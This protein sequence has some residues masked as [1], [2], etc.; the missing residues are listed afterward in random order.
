MKE[1][2]CAVIRDLLPLYEDNAVS[3]E[4][5]ELVREH[6]ANCPDCR[7]ELR[8]MR[9][10]ISLP[11]DG[12]EEAVRRFL[13]RR[14][15]IR[16]KQNVKIACVASVLAVILVFCLCYTLIPRSWDSVSHGVEPDRIMGDYSLFVFRNDSPSIEVW[17]TDEEYQY[18]AAVVNQVMDALRSCSYRADL[19]NVL[20]N[21]PIAPFFQDTG[22]EG[23]NGT[24]FLSLVKDNQVAAR[25]GLYSTRRGQI[26]CVSFP[27]NP[28]DFYYRTDSSLFDELTT[29]IQ[30]YGTQQ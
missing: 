10:P 17:L 2:N 22:T 23:L 13:E 1:I 16:K 3:E 26:I 29:L 8:K 11:P 6:L 21:T 5:A 18:D 14:A 20:N 28:N 12:D 7:E 25:L 19:R 4:T 30:R 27:G 24:V 15:E 9:T